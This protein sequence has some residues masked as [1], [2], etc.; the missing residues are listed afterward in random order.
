MTLEWT[1]ALRDWEDRVVA[2]GPLVPCDPLFP[3]E[4]ESALAIFTGLRIVDAPGSPTI[5]QA[6]RPWVLD[7]ARAIFGSYD[8]ETGERLIRYF[9]LLVAK[10][11][12]KSTLAAGIML[13]ALIRNWRRSAEFLIFAPTVEVAGN[14]FMPARDMIRADDELNDLLHIQ[15]HMRMITHRQTGA[16]LKVVAADAE[17]ASGKKASGVL[18]DELWLFGK[19]ANAENMLREAT[20]GLASRPEG[21]VIYLSTQSD[22]PPAGVFAQTLAEFRGIRD[23]KIAD[24]R[25][26]GVLYE[27]PPAMLKSQ[28][29]RDPD[30]WHITN[31]NLGA[32][33]DLQY[34]LDERG[35]AERAGEASFRGFAAKHLNIE[36]GI[37]LRA[38]GWA[39][40]DVW[41]RGAEFGL[42]FATLLERSEVVTVGIDGGGLDDLLG[43]A[44]LGRE[45]NTK[46]WLLWTHAFIS[47]EGEERRKANA[48]VYE[49][50]KADG[51][52]TRVEQLPDDLEAVVEIVRQVKEY[53]T[54]AMVGVDAIGIGGIV[55]ALAEIQVTEQSGILKGVRQGISLMGSIKTIERKLADGTFKHDGSR[56][57]KWCVGNARIIPTPTAMRIARDEAGLGKIDPLMAAFDAAELMIAGPVALDITAMIA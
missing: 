11:N 43:I 14:S 22:Q 17:T 39:G 9:L 1:T 3:A 23:G 49:N 16:T 41:E 37:A 52:L 21:F 20:G 15:E 53:G 10:K 38:D 34:L 55:D 54:L 26:L 19:R 29:F 32:S 18:I 51:D 40:A 35:K 12:S 33:V 6:C 57:M 4:A 42:N 46:N 48:S 45:R 13:T 44:V 50:F 27:Y 7:F 8:P 30:T 31:P 47:P 36:I 56:L 28:A 5:G 24:P 2:G 25:S